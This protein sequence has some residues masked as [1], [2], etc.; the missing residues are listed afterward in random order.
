MAALGVSRYLTVQQVMALGLGAR[1]EKATGYRLRGLA[2]EG[3]RSKVRAFHPPLLRDFRFRS[4]DGQW[5]QL[6]ALTPAG[7]RLAGQELGQPLQP[8]RTDIGAEFAEH[9]VFL[10]D[11]L[12]RLLR[13]FLATGASLRQLPF[14]WEVVGDVDLPWRERDA[15][16]ERRTRVLRPDAV[17]TLPTA[18]RRLFVECETGSNSLV[19]ESPQ[20]RQAV[21]SKLE[22]Y[23]TFLSGFADKAPG[24]THYQR[25]YPDGWPCDV[26][27]LSRTDLRTRNTA[28]AVTAFLSSRPEARFGARAL[29]L[30]DAAA[31]VESLLRSSAGQPV[32]ARPAAG[33]FYGEADHQAVKDFVLEMSAALAQANAALRRKR[34]TP[35]GEPASGRRM[36]DFLRRAQAEMGRRRAVDGRPRP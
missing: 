32:P 31:H 9:F 15:E 10:T 19:P 7:Y 18:K 20:R 14:R 25:R 5:L 8:P 24:A 1:T 13:P 27:F 30:A 35:V 36:A 29:T 2:G 21:L 6:W 26:V 11:L 28:D 33:T 22:R 17:L 3:T 4:F 34:L 16:G 12:V 23:D